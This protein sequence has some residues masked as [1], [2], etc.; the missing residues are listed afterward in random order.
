MYVMSHVYW[1]E[2]AGLSLLLFF[3]VQASTKTTTVYICDVLHAVQP[4]MMI[5]AVLKL[6]TK[7]FL[8]SFVSFSTFSSSCSFLFQSVLVLEVCNTDFFQ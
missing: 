6:G 3:L 8:F 4:R 1:P 7:Q 5:L 2:G